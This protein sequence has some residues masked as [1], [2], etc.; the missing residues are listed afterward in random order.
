MFGLL[1]LD[2]AHAEFRLMPRGLAF[3]WLYRDGVGVLS[4]VDVLQKCFCSTGGHHRPAVRVQP[5]GPDQ[6][7]VRGCS[8][9]SHCEMKPILL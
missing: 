4:E 2:S 9:L 7:L 8:S 5:R 1:W 6:S 3:A